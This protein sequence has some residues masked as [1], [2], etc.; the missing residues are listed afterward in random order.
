MNYRL[1]PTDMRWR[2]KQCQRACA[3]NRR[4]IEA[5]AFRKF[6]WECYSG[7]RVPG[8]GRSTGRRVG[9]G[10][11]GSDHAITFPVTAWGSK[12]APLYFESCRKFA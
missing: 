12:Y 10:Q 11:E 2:L 1:I 3:N 7:I 6:R 5:P 8:A 4:I 9:M